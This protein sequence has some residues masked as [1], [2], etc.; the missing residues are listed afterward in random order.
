M[1]VKKQRLK[2][3]IAIYAGPAPARLYPDNP[4]PD[5]HEARRYA[6]YRRSWDCDDIEEFYD[7]SNSGREG[8]ELLCEEV[9]SGRF[10]DVICFA[11]DR[12]GDQSEIDAFKACLRECGVKLHVVW[13]AKHAKQEKGSD[14]EVQASAQSTS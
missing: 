4:W 8:R 7:T 12:I 14:S 1:N 5:L 9:R 13:H 6:E 2:K 3:R 10:T 11:A